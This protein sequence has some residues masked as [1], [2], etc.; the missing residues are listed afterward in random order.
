M[1]SFSHLALVGVSLAMLSACGGGGD[2]PP[3]PPAAETEA[4][5]PEPAAAATTAEAPP[6]ESTDTIDGT[7]LADFTGDAEAG[8]TVFLQC[9]SCHVGDPGVN[10]IGPSL[11]G[12]VGREAGTVEGY[13]YTE[14]NA[15]S[16][17]TWTPEK[18]FQYL[19]NPQRVVPGTKMAFAGLSDPQ[20]RADVIAHLQTFSQ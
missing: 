16:G 4:A 19:E 6:P 20:D 7:V 12:I 17:I 10:R 1:K 9:G 18:L 11:A 2:E 5:T 3:P 14:A 8:S 15:N 13:Q